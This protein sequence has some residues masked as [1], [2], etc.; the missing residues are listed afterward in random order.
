MDPLK[1]IKTQLQKALNECIRLREE[2]TRLKNLLDLPL[3]ETSPS[4]KIT[5]AEP[6]IT[7]S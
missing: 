3:E 2:N 4:L 6:R 7:Y 1:D 5:F